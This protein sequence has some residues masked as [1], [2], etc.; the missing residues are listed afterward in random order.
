MNTPLFSKKELR[1]IVWRAFFLQHAFNFSRMQGVGFLYTILPALRKIYKD[2]QEGL[3]KAMLRHTDFFNTH[4]RVHAPIV[5]MV[6]AMEE[7]KEDPETIRAFK[8]ATMGPIAGIGDSMFNFMY[9]PVMRGI[10]GSLAYSGAWIALPLGLFVENLTKLLMF[11]PL[12]TV[13]DLGSSA[14]IKIQSHM[15]QINRLATNIGLMSLGGLSA[16]YISVQF[17]LEFTLNDK[18]FSVQQDIFDQLM[19][20][21]LSLVT[22]LLA[23]YLIRVKKW[24]IQMLIWSIIGICLVASYFNILK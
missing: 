16:A 10:V 19:P 13:Y 23:F 15:R 8:I 21:I 18:T 2:D 3:A 22:L 7:H 14:L 4:P 1:M 6:I 5:A 20:S 24:N 12:Y 17:A 9:D 11:K